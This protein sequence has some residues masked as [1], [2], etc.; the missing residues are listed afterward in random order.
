MQINNIS[1]ISQEVSPYN[2]LHT[3]YDWLKQVDQRV[4]IEGALKVIKEGTSGSYLIRDD[5]DCP[6]AI[7]KPEDEAGGAINNPKGW[8][9]LDSIDSK[10]PAV[11][12]HAAW[13]VGRSLTSIPETHIVDLI[14]EGKIQRGSLQ[15][16]AKN[17]GDCTDLLKLLLKGKEMPEVSIDQ[18]HRIALFD[19]MIQNPDRDNPGN[20]LYTKSEDGTINLIPI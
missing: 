14:R 5:Q 10:E 6:L 8:Q 20:L 12:E 2:H 1:T 13:L 9:T 16:Y 15:R 11:R 18:I 19:L 17:D 4:S 7:Y 3:D